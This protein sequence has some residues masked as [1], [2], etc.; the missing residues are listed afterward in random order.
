MLKKGLLTAALIL[1]V[2]AQAEGLYLQAN[3]GIADYDVANAANVDSRAFMFDAGLG[4]QFT[5]YFALEGGYTYLGALDT[6]NPEVALDQG[7]R[8]E[9]STGGLELAAAFQWP[10]NEKAAVYAKAGYYFW[11]MTTEQPSDAC[12]CTNKATI[13]TVTGSDPT[14]A[15]G[16]E[17]NSWLFEYQRYQLRQLDINSL[18]LGYRVRF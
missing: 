1:P 9:A 10:I 7:F 2:A 12:T 6:S 5:D 18:T 17:Y 11:E 8:W 16:L 14:F 3:G 15:A 13:Y 4:Y